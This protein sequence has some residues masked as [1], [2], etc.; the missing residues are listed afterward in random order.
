VPIERNVAIIVLNMP[1]PH[2]RRDFLKTAVLAPLAANL[3]PTAALAAI[4]P[5]K[6]VGGANLRVSLNAYSF[7][8]MLNDQLLGR[9][10][11]ISLTELAEFAAKQNF[12]AIDPTAY[13]FPGYRER[14]PPPDQFL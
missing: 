1:A 12:D 5:P 2:S 14:K 4:E 3:G 6:R 7:A 9:G 10:A 8:K 11:G 13:Y